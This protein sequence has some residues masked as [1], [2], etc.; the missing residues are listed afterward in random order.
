MESIEALEDAIEGYDG[1]VILVSHDRALLR[2]LT[3][4][5]W[6]LHEGRIS[7]FPGGFAEWETV[8]TERAHA[9]A[10]ASAEEEALRRVH[11]RKQTR[12]VEDGRKQEQS[13]RRRAQQVVQE[14]EVRVT[15]GE[16]RVAAIRAQLEIP[17]LSRHR[18]GHHLPALLGIELSRPHG[19]FRGGAAGVGSGQRRNQ[20]IVTLIAGR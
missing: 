7:D 2:A 11:E 8:S 18:G 17:E 6:V 5:V 16:T 19:C 12:R 14:A 13:A 15:S 3:N 9:A 4:R 20:L 10:V 1:T